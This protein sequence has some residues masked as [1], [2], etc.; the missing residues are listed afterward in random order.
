MHLKNYKKSVSIF[1]ICFLLLGFICTHYLF[2]KRTEDVVLEVISPVEFKLQNGN[3]YRVNNI[4]TFDSNYTEKNKIFGE[5][6]NISEDEA[7]IMG[8]FAKY[9][10]K[11]LVEN[12]NVSFDNNNMVYYKFDYKTKL[13]NSSFGI[14]DFHPTNPKAFE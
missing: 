6:L 8:N 13:E 10:A 4:E 9:W 7:F 14:K 12:R 11:N 2:N 5:K 1:L 3:I